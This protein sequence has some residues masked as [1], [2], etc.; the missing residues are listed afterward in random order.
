MSLIQHHFGT[1]QALYSAVKEDALARYMRSQAAT[2]AQ[3]D[4]A[5]GM[6]VEGG[7]RRF[8]RFFEASPEWVRLNAWAALEGD[9]S[10]WP[11]EEPFVERIAAE[12]RRGQDKGLVPSDI[13]ADLLLIASAGLMKAW[14]HYRERHAHRLTHL[15]T[16]AQQEEKYLA[17]CMRLLLGAPARPPRKRR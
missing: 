13:D 2:V 8:F 16:P 14:V 15:G 10:M 3:A 12:V 6:F 1:K 5:F 17:L 4:V 11:G 7:L 9:N